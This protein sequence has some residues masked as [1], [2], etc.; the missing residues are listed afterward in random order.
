MRVLHC[1]AGLTGDGAQRLL[2]RLTRGLQSHAV[3][4]V[5]VNLG[6]ATP[7]VS[8]FEAA[9]VPVISLGMLPAVRDLP[10]AVAHLRRTI[11]DL[12]PDLVQGWMYHANVMA[13]LARLAGRYNLPIVWNIR[14]GLDDYR[15]RSL[16]TRAVIRMSS[17]FSRYV[18]SIIYC[19]EKSRYQ[20]ETFGYAPSGGRVMHNGFD[21]EKFAPSPRARQEARALFGAQDDEVIIGNIGRYD[22]AKGHRHLLEAFALV[23]ACIRKVRLV[24]VGRGMDPDNSDISNMITRAGI[25]ER[26]TLLGERDR[27]ERIYPGF[28]IYCSSS[29]SEGFPNVIAEAMACALPCVVTDVGGTAEI[30]EQS[31]ILAAPR[32][33]GA[34]AKGLDVYARLSSAERRAIGEKARARVCK[35]FSLEAMVTNYAQMYSALRGG[36]E[37]ASRSRSVTLSLGAGSSHSEGRDGHALSDGV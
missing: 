36:F 8:D 25:A 20:H 24:C 14:R 7:L 19:S 15:E 30:V 23:A 13:L 27:V 18:E 12:E 35:A 26:V 9:N 22:I 1:I 31:A 11:H 34:L 6:Q 33:S 28:D 5:I 10:G 32:N 21:T 16:S 4:S 2:L 37:R 3:Q 17:M 29:I